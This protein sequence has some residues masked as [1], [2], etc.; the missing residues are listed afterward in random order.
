MDCILY[1]LLWTFF[2]K[3]AVRIVMVHYPTSMSISERPGGSFVTCMSSLW[4]RVYTVLFL[5]SYVPNINH[6]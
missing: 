4:D 2:L 3:E 5:H 1:L 6:N